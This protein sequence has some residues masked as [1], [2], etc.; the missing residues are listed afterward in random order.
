[1]SVNP[2]VSALLTIGVGTGAVA[3][4]EADLSALYAD[5]MKTL[6]KVQET[7]DEQLVR[8][9]VVAWQVEHGAE[10]TPS[11]EELVAAGYLDESYTK[12]EKLQAP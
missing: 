4:S 7:N 11:V 12:R 5:S 8:A 10:R 3:L 1:M 6:A 9:A 2:W